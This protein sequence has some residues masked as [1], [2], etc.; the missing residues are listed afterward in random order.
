MSDSEYVC[1][2]MCMCV[3]VCGCVCACLYV[4]LCVCVCV[5][6]LICTCLLV[7]ECVCAR[8]HFCVCVWGCVSVFRLMKWKGN[9]SK[10]IIVLPI[11]D[12]LT[13]LMSLL[14]DLKYLMPHTNLSFRVL[15]SGW[16]GDALARGNASVELYTDITGRPIT[17]YRVAFRLSNNGVQSEARLSGS[18]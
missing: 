3:C 5:C 6:M 1:V 17:G 7:C 15:Q 4:W 2:C 13:I 16:L 8:M 18:T 9:S 12:A 14:W 11:L 10:S